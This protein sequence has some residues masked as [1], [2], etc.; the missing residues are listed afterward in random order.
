MPQG[1]RQNACS[2]TGSVVDAAVRDNAG[3]EIRRY[4]PYLIAEV[5]VSGGYA[6]AAGG[7]FN[8]LVGYIFGDNS[9]S[10][11]PRRRTG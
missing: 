2:R 7:G 11:Y 5:E 6:H 9:D 8:L 4:D 3:Y 1:R 10:H